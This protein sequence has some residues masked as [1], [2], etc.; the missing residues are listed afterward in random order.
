MSR[1]KKKSISRTKKKY[2]NKSKK[3]NNRS[4]NKY[5]SRTKKQ[6]IKNKNKNINAR[7]IIK[8]SFGGFVEDMNTIKKLIESVGGNVELVVFEDIKYEL[9]KP[10]HNIKFKHVDI[11]FFIE[12]V[13]VED[14]LK[15]FPADK[16]YIF[17]NQEYMADWDYDRMKDKTV[18]PLCKTQVSYRQLK[19]LGINTVKYI[20][21][22]NNTSIL[23]DNI[24][25]KNN[26]QLSKIPNLFV[27]IAGQSPLKGTIILIKTWN[28]KHIKEPLIITAKNQYGGNTKLF[29][30]WKSLRPT[31]IKGLPDIAGLKNAWDMHLH[32]IEI[33]VFEKVG[34]IYLCD[35]TLDINI[36]RF[37][38][39]VAD[40]HMCP[41]A[42]EGWGQ[43]ID[44]GRRTKSVVLTL[45]APPM[46]ELIDVK[47]GI[48][49]S[50]MKGPSTKQ[51]LPPNWTQ[52]LSKF[53]NKDTY[54][55]NI[56]NM[57]IKIQDIL[58][59][60]ESE[61]RKMGENAFVKSK[62]DYEFFKRHFM[63]L[64]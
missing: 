31:K 6:T 58:K 8:Q 52:Y 3:Y 32:N 40:V 27:H 42:M 23:I 16:S 59:M 9:R 10:S 48:L 49:V 2:S 17:I 56:N 54:T 47:S 30:Y 39:N 24:D 50:A 7:I 64:L 55:T 21:F 57:Y 36:I 13:Y 29:N 19:Q 35:K 44:E 15:L 28:D 43:Y 46:N 37:L 20:G 25:T 61:K 18:I 11:Q 51:I 38:Q 12:H 14:P 45:D 34:S 53:A 63:K 5:V 26:K 22:G 4:N 41:S 33:P 62:K 1:I 60:T